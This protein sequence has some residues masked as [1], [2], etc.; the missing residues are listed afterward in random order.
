MKFKV[1]NLQ[2]KESTTDGLN[3]KIQVRIGGTFHG[4]LKDRELIF[5]ANKCNDYPSI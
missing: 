5:I 2:I 4:S 3:S 1:L